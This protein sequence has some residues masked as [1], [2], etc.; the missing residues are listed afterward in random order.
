MTVFQKWRPTVF[1]DPTYGLLFASL[2]L[3]AALFIGLAPKLGRIPD[4]IP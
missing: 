3:L 4:N 2:L 1:L